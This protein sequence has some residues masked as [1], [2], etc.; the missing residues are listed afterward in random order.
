MAAIDW[1]GMARLAGDGCKIEIPTIEKRRDMALYRLYLTLFDMAGE[2][3]FIE[4][5]EW[6]MKVATWAVELRSYLA[7]KGYA[8]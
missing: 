7:G 3:E 5:P 2:P 4:S 8:V 1:E 6:T